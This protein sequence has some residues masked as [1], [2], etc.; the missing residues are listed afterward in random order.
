MGHS[1]VSTDRPGSQTDPEQHFSAGGALRWVNKGGV[2]LFCQCGSEGGGKFSQSHCVNAG[3]GCTQST[4]LWL[5]AVLLSW[6][7]VSIATSFYTWTKVKDS[8]ILTI[9]FYSSLTLN[10]SV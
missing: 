7:I 6:V 1:S 4:P 3:G 5:A 8:S 10:V 9:V 2:E